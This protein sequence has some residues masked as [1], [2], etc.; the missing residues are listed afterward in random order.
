MGSLLGVLLKR[1]S[2]D[3]EIHKRR[4]GVFIQL[5]KQAS[6]RELFTPFVRALKSAD[7][8]TAKVILTLL[9]QVNSVSEHR[10]IV[11]LF[12]SSEARV[13]RY[14]IQAFTKVGGKTAFG[15]LSRMCGERNFPGRMEAMSA[16][17]EVVA[18]HCL[19]ALQGVVAAG[20]PPEKV[21]ALQ[22]LK[23][24][25]LFGSR[26][27]EAIESI[28]GAL[29][30]ASVEV[31]FEAI[32]ALG[33]LADEGAFFDAVGGN[34]ESEDQ[35]IVIATLKAM[36]RF[37]S[38]RAI[39]ILK[40]RFLMGPKAIRLAVLETAEGMGSKEAVPLL[41]EGLTHKQLDVRNHAA[42]VLE[43]M[44]K[45]N[46]INLARA[47]LWLLR[48][49]DIQ[50][51]RMAAQLANCVRD[52]DGKLWPQLFRYLRDEDWWVRERITD[53]L[54]EMAGEHLTRFAV[55]YLKD[56]NEI[57]RRYGIELMVRL[58]D[59]KAIGALVRAASQDTDWWVRERA[60]E[61]LGNL[62]DPRAVPYLV[63]LI[64]KH[65]DLR[66]V[67][68]T[69]LAE[70]G[71]RAALPHVAKIAA[72]CKD[73]DAQ[74]SALRCMQRFDD[75][76][77]APVV[78]KALQSTDYRVRTLARELLTRWNA[79]ARDGI[80]AAERLSL[81][82]RMLV[83]TVKAGG[84]D[85]MMAPNKRP[86]IKRHGKVIPVSEELFTHDSVV[87]LIHPQLSVQQK[88]DLEEMKDVD[89][90]YSVKAE[91]LRF[92]V[93][94]FQQHGGLSAVFRVVKDDVPDLLDLGLP[95]IVN[96]FGDIPHG[97]IL[98]GG[99]TGSGKST[100][101]AALI[102][103]INR[104][105]P[106]NILTLEDPIEVLHKPKDALISQREIGTNTKSFASALRSAFRQDPD[107]ILVG[108]MRDEE[109]LRSAL[110][111]AETGHLVF[112]TVHTAAAD[113]TVDR[114][115]NAFPADDQPQVR[116]MLANNL[117]AICCQHLMKRCDTDGRVL[118]VEV[119]MNNDAIANLIRKGRTFQI[120]NVVATSREQGMESMDNALFALAASGKITADDAYMKC[121]YKKEFGSRL[122]REGITEEYAQKY[123]DGNKEGATE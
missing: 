102:S 94:V 117:R 68:C 35:R 114:I 23:D 15:A 91:G 22:Y 122:A 54:V 13:R 49:P 21:R 69:A 78:E 60:I 8:A 31:V 11:D 92:R 104:T 48:S 112:G 97:L 12:K 1:K 6:H 59:P 76:K 83:E 121:M 100:T 84:D 110:T 77:A 108:E 42:K 64:G 27:A 18:R 16:M 116:T 79:V 30:D 52:V 55:K 24:E 5:G 123:A 19:P 105:Y 120:P 33:A 17:M 57:I 10:E 61:A 7:D 34:L 43:R 85:L 119:M 39:K 103:Y 96:G 26:K 113:T 99:P 36:G 58:N 95:E 101:L 70:I 106:V 72:S 9:P 75:P 32:Q 98:V 44:A 25:E 47:I 107:V 74:L 37:T 28:S 29:S 109:T 115:I 88:Q 2:G 65:R 80:D 46:H 90:S 86:Y 14:A 63:D 111:A 51:K 118:A 87:Q 81:L 45:R 20:S 93:N 50:V 71:D 4:C 82:A 73:A 67:G 89:F 56:D 66:I 40:R 41:L 3:G 53:A 62:K 38:P